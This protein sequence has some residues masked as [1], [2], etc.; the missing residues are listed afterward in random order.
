MSKYKVTI[1]VSNTYTY[2]TDDAAYDEDAVAEAF[3]YECMWQAAS[4]GKEY[5]VK[6]EAVDD[7]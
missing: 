5:D 3:R 7:E 2:E 6:V 1:K 4:G